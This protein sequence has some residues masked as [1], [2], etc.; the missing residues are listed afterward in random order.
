[1]TNRPAIL[2]ME[3]VNVLNKLG[4]QLREVTFKSYPEELKSARIERF[5]VDYPDVKEIVFYDDLYGHFLDCQPLVEKYLK[6]DFNFIL[7]QNETLIAV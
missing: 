1:M 7:V 4:V 2:K 5:I 6:I 3:V